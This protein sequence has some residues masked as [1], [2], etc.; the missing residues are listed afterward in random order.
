MGGASPSG[1]VLV[2]LVGCSVRAG[3]PRRRQPVSVVVSAISEAAPVIAARQRPRMTLGVRASIRSPARSYAKMAIGGEISG[4][5]WS[6]GSGFLG[7]FRT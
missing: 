6:N 3:R 1:A 5:V 2:V 7:A 4:V